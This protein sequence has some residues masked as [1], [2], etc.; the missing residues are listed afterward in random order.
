MMLMPTSTGTSSRP[1]WHDALYILALSFIFFLPG[2][3]AWFHGDDFVHVH[4]L[5]KPDAATLERIVTGRV[6]SLQH[7]HNYR[8]LTNLVFALVAPLDAAWAYRLCSLIIHLANGLLIWLLLHR[9]VTSRFA[10][11]TATLFFLVN[12]AIHTTVLWISALADLLCTF[13]VLAT[14]YG[15]AGRPRASRSIQYITMT[16]LVLAALTAKEMAV[17][18]PALLWIT[19]LYRHRARRDALFIVTA[20]FI[21]FIYIFIRGHI[22][23][24]MGAGPRTAYYLTPG[25]STLVSAAK[26]AFSLLVPIPLHWVWRW[27]ILVLT[28]GIPVAMTALHLWQSKAW[29]AVRRIL[30]AFFFIGLSLA[31]VINVYAD[32]YLYL[33][34]V[35]MALGAAFVFSRPTRKWYRSA[36]ILYLLICALCMSWWQ[37][38]FIQ[39]GRW[40]QRILDRISRLPDEPC[41]IA[42]LPRQYASIP[43]LSFSH[44][45]N[46]ALT[47]F[48]QPRSPVQTPAPT[49]IASLHAGPD[50]SDA[51][52]NRIKLQ[53]SGRDLNWFDIGRARNDP[54][55]ETYEIKQCNDLGLPTTLTL[56]LSPS[57]RIP[58]Y[59]YRCAPNGQI[60]LEKRN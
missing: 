55:Q 9:L 46:Q 30:F 20:F 15:Y 24:S 32:W 39:A 57:N 4:Q 11:N 49:C 54:W 44:H 40:E 18:L 56:T 1:A 31:P 37:G 12:P 41:A 33:P 19:A 59:V 14:L 53:F 36:I 16:L 38:A 27:P 51:G 25:I 60:I 10:I 43:L 7:D 22:I 23:Q 26:Y 29:A 35:G 17:T 50:I 6:Y 52:K 45:I 3:D 42:G 2:L 21:V 8:P 48:A 13:F 58:L 28:G 47:L 34:S 5:Q